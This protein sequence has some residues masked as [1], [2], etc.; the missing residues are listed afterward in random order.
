VDKVTV[1]LDPGS[2]HMGRLEY[3]IELIDLAIDVKADYIKFQMGVKPPNIDV[4]KEWWPIL[5]E[6]A[7][8]KIGVTASTFGEASYDF[9]LTQ[10]PPF[11][12]FAY[13]Q[14]YRRPEMLECLKLGIKTVVSCD[15]MNWHLVPEGCKRLYCLPV[16][17]VPYIPNFEGL[18]LKFHGF[19]DHTIGIEQT[20]KAVESGFGWIEKH[21]SLYHD[22]IDCPDHNFALEPFELKKMM[23]LL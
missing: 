18:H 1:C 5:R 3:A 9:M 14:N 13:S 22:D 6:R 8:D 16:Y 21:F 2:C 4:P 11:M 7:G 23:R 12:K 19:S 17:P 10:N 20:I 15:L